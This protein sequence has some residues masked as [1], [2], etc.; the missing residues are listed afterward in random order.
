MT[1][2]SRSFTLEE[3]CRSPTAQRMGRPI[4]ATQDHLDNLRRLC[5]LVL[6]PFR[7]ALCKPIVITSGLRP[8]WL[9]E[10]IGGSKTSAHMDGRAADL[11]VPGMP[12]IEVCRFIRSL[13]LEVDQLIHEFPPGGW[14]HVG[15]AKVGEIARTQYLTA[16]LKDGVTHY[17]QGLNA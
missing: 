8:P 11:E 16:R 5:T 6:Q 9:N 4:V 13:R 2:L 10:A 7:D 14:T 17:E 12:P 3:F 1:H 15:I